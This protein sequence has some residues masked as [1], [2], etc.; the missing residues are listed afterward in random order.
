MRGARTLVAR[1]AAIVPLL[2]ACSGDAADD[3]STETPL[4]APAKNGA[5]RDP[6]SSG[7]SSS[8]TSSAPTS[9]AGAPAPSATTEPGAH[10]EVVQLVMAGKDGWTWFCTGALVSKSVVVTAAHCLQSAL[11]DSWTAIFPMIESRPR[12]KGTPLMYDT[13][14]TDV[15]HPDLGIVRLASPVALDHYASL[16]DVTARIAAGEKLSVAAIVRTEERAEATMARTKD[17]ALFSTANRGYTSGYG[18]PL[19]SHGGDSGAGMFLVVNGV[20]THELVAVEREPDPDTDTDQL[21]RIDR[22]FIDW[23]TANG[24]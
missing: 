23:V 10:A 13:K 15:A 9:G 20:M 22:A 12:V 4:L 24:G 3:A 17:L 8:S 5:A 11:F 6:A 16:T 1:A 14:W 19:Y 7:A 21:S 2:V 18:V